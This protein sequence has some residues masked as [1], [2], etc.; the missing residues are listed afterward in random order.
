MSVI[1]PFPAV[2]TRY[3]SLSVLRSPLRVVAPVKLGKVGHLLRHP[4]LLR[5]FYSGIRV[6]FIGQ[7]PQHFDEISI[8]QGTQ[9][10]RKSID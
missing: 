7:E 2:A 9:T 4:T 5:Y 3:Q 10:D 1:L 8:Q 6:L